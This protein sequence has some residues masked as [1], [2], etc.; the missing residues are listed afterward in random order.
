MRPKL[1]IV[2]SLGQNS[3]DLMHAKSVAKKYSQKHVECIVYFDDIVDIV[4]NVIKTFKTF[5]PLEIRNS[6]VIFFGIREAKDRGYDAVV[7]G[8]GADE[9]FAGYNYLQRYFTDL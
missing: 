5:D 8:D 2:T 7:T 6:S 9:L 4:P 3:Q 1:S